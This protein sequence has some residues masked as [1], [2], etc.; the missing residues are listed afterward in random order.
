MSDRFRIM[1][2]GPGDKTIDIFDNAGVFIIT[3]DY[4]DVNH[5][6]IDQALPAL[7]DALNTLNMP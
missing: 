7:L 6:A 5:G 4:D 1:K 2:R 3:I